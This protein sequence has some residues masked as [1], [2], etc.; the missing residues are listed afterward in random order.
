MMDK[1]RRL[2]WPLLAVFLLTACSGGKG[3]YGKVTD[4]ES[5]TPLGSATVELMECNA[6]GCEE[7]VAS[8]FTSADGR[9][10]FPDVAPGRYLL[11][12]TWK[13]S[14]D[15]S[16]ITPF[17]T[18]GASGEFVVMYAGYGGLGGT[19]ARSMI[20]V[21]EFDLKEGQNLRLDLEFACP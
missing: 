6:S 17:E 16:G 15:C 10:E 13:S 12:I 1:Y 11:S 4:G 2:T 5:R 3:I 9:Y 8:Q 20:A 7:S 21:K 19:G 14:P 18:L